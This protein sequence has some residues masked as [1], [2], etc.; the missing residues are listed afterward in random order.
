MSGI[1]I[2]LMGTYCGKPSVPTDSNSVNATRATNWR[3]DGAPGSSSDFHAAVSR[4]GRRAETTDRDF[5]LPLMVVIPSGRWRSLYGARTEAR[6]TLR[7]PE[8]IPPGQQLSAHP[9]AAHQAG[10]TGAAVDV[11]LTAVVVLAGRTAHRLRRGLGPDRVDPAGA[12]PFVH[13]RD[14]VVPHRPP[15]AD[16]QGP[17]GSERMHA[18][19]EEQLGAVHVADPRHDLL[20][21]QQVADRTV[22]PADPRPGACRVRVV[23]QRVGAEPCDHLRPAGRRDEVADDRAAE[24]GVRPGPDESQSTLA[25]RL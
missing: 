9:P 12:D 22:A 21:H 3:R 2:T 4:D 16:A 15:L 5:G 10:L 6:L 8:Q 20:V 18:V 11:D 25:D 14:Q 7:T 13:Q 23:P 19:P 1:T 17:A 24:V